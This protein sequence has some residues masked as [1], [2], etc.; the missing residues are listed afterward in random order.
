MKGLV[1]R[2]TGSFYDVL[3]EG[4][5]HICRVRGKIR[6][7]GIKETN[8]VAVGDY[9]SFELENDYGS[10]TEILD[11]K[12][13][14]LRKS[15]KKTGHS[16]VLAANIDQAMMV[17]T[18]SM[19]RTSLGFIDRFLVS[20]EAFRIPQ[21][22]VFNKR[23]L[24]DDESRDYVDS[25]MARYR[26]IGV[27]CFSISAKQDDL[28][29]IQKL[30]TNKITLVAGHSGVGKS[31]LLNKISPA[32]TQTVGDISDFSSKGTHTT[33]FAEMFK[34]AEETFVIDTPGVKEWG[35]VDMTDQELSDY[36]PEMRDVRLDC[37]FGSRCIHI[38]EPKCAVVEAVKNGVI[39]LERYESYLSMIDNDDNRK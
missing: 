30:L 21:V 3:S 25:L 31:T 5:K 12:N 20:A 11:R 24:L 8:P 4:K 17:A 32:I 22:I 14:I 19:P 13:H 18:L 34:I 27:T 33:T 2:S 35:L 28:S 23:D 36:F 6:L 1:M 37:K 15:I 26:N 38:K 29:E 7:A 9:V 39:A 10:I 16:H